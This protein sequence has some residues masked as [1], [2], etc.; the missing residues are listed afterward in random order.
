MRCDLEA[1]GVKGKIESDGDQEGSN[2]DE[3][4][5]ECVSKVNRKR[6]TRVDSQASNGNQEPRNEQLNLRKETGEENVD[7][8]EEWGEE[9]D[10][11][12]RADEGVDGVDNGGDNSSDEVRELV[13]ALAFLDRGSEGATNEFHGDGTSE[14]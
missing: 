6:R 3:T 11:S 4:E 13:A 9:F 14:G 7:V 1:K 10:I 2:V 5:I 12:E 8:V